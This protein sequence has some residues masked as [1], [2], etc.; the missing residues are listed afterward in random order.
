MNEAYV[1]SDLH[2]EPDG[3]GL[4][5][6]ESFCEEASNARAI[7]NGD[8][9]NILPHGLGA[10]KTTQGYNTIRHFEATVEKYLPLH[11][12]D[13]VLGNHEGRKSWVEELIQG[14]PLIRLHRYLDLQF[15]GRSGISLVDTYHFEHGHRFTEWRVLSWFA[16]DIV[17]WATTNALTRRWWYEFSRRMGWMPGSHPRKKEPNEWHGIYLGL[18]YWDAIRREATYN[19]TDVVGHSHIF[20]YVPTEFGVRVID[21]GARRTIKLPLEVKDE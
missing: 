14:H 4:Q 5:F 11:G 13:Y 15:P 17:E 7:L 21:C 12:L 9:L 3:F 19:V 8:G 18:V 16:D 10:W 2:I 20:A 1:T 6:L